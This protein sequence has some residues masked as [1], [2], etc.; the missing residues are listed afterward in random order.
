MAT[1]QG[2]HRV[3]GL[4][5]DA[6][7][8]EFKGWHQDLTGRSPPGDPAPSNDPPQ[9]RTR[10]RWLDLAAFA[11]RRTLDLERDPVIRPLLEPMVAAIT[12]RA[13]ELH[14]RS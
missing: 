4:S 7:L 1:R 6:L 2:R 9:P 12:K 14:A 5:L 3:I 8:R 13:I 10:I 11:L